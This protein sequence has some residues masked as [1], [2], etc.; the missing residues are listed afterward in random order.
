MNLQANIYKTRNRAAVRRRRKVTDART[1]AKLNKAQTKAA[2]NKNGM[3]ASTKA[4]DTKLIEIQALSPTTKA[5]LRDEQDG[6]QTRSSAV[7]SVRIRH[8]VTPKCG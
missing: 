3:K 6:I 5:F 4:T 1:V 7:T 8:W 2:E